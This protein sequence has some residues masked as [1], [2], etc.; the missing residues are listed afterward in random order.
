L[1]RFLIKLAALLGLTA[2]LRW[3]DSHFEREV[4]GSFGSR[5]PMVELSSAEIVQLSDTFMEILAGDGDPAFKGRAIVGLR[6]SA[7]ALSLRTR[8]GRIP[9]DSNTERD[10]RALA[11][12]PQEM[13]KA[14]LKLL[15]DHSGFKWL[16]PEFADDG[17][18]EGSAP[19][20]PGES[21]VADAN[22]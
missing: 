15:A 7:L 19:P 4:I 10:L 20:A 18:A 16:D 2:K 11:G 6:I 14:G 8:H 21:E 17:P 3:D 12:A 9:F 1:I 13:V 5:Y 22:P